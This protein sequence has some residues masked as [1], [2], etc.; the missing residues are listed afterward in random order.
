LR[1]QGN[2]PDKGVER[3]ITIVVLDMSLCL[4]NVGRAQASGRVVES[5]A[6]GGMSNSLSKPFTIVLAKGQAGWFPTEFDL[7]GANGIVQQDGA[8]NRGQPVQP[9]TNR[10]SATD[11]SGR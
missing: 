2:G 4:L 1:P 3:Q 8:A 10:T 5:Y 9:A 6:A 11:G 7:M